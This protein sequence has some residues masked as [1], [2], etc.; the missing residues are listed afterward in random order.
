MFVKDS[1]IRIFLIISK[2]KK[3]INQFTMIEFFFCFYF[4]LE[5]K[6]TRMEICIFLEIGNE[7]KREREKERLKPK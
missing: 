1:K 6:W 2:F 5:R 7:T 4:I 3:K